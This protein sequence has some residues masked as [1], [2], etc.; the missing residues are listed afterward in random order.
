MSGGSCRSVFEIPAFTSCAAASTS[1]SSENWIVICVEPSEPVLVMLSITAIVESCFS[2]AVA[3]GA[4][5]VP[6]LPRAADAL[7]LGVSPVPA[8]REGGAGATAPA[9]RPAL[10][11]ALGAALGTADVPGDPLGARAPLAPVRPAVPAAAP[12]L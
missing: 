12:P 1:R 2:S 4:A 5:L 3:T 9:P 7:A 11:A 8:T 10:G 6:A